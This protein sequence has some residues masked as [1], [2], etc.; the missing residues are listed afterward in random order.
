MPTQGSCEKTNN[1][2]QR[3]KGAESRA[4]QSR[5]PLGVFCGFVPQA[6]DE[7][8]LLALGSFRGFSWLAWTTPSGP[9]EVQRIA[10][11][12]MKVRDWSAQQ[13]RC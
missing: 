2:T 11:F 4:E 7:M 5:G 1:L 10:R 13:K 12:L 6:R 3:R 8:L 9:V